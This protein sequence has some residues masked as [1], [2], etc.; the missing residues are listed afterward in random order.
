M[1]RNLFIALAALVICSSCG[2]IDYLSENEQEL[3]QLTA[4]YENAKYQEEKSKGEDDFEKVETAAA[5]SEVKSIMSEYAVELMNRPAVAKEKVMRTAYRT[6]ASIVGV[7]KVNTC[8]SY[9]ELMV[10]IDCEDSREDSGT[11]GNVGASRVDGNG[12]VD[13]QFCLTSA[14]R[15]YPGGVFLVDHINYSMGFTQGYYSYVRNMAVFVRHHDTEDNKPSN[16]AR[17]TDDFYNIKENYSGYTQIGTD[18]T[19]AWGFPAE[20]ALCELGSVY[21]PGGI[22]YGLLT[23]EAAATG[24]I[25]FDDEDNN[26]KNWFQRYTA[27]T[28]LNTPSADRVRQLFGVTCTINTN[29]SISLSTDPKFSKNNIYYA[30]RLIF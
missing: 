20:F 5:E 18:V 21:H 26:N 10:H 11:W 14:N 8:G 28:T 2:E 3:A 24:G 30:P 15:Y 19:L 17:S 22:D 6:V 7:F 13:L 1:K 16:Y 23:P 27:G 29:Y 25:Y 12:N 9:K 4:E